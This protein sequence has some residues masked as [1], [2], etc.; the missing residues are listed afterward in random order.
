MGPT[1]EPTPPRTLAEAALAAGVGLV[2]H[3]VIEEA[4]RI[5]RKLH[6][7]LRAHGAPEGTAVHVSWSVG[8]ELATIQVLHSIRAGSRAGKSLPPDTEAVLTETGASAAGP[9]KPRKRSR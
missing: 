3:A 2:V 7:R 5:A 9:E 6:L 1:T 8:D 4:H